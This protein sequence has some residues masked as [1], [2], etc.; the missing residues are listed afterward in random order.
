MGTSSSG[1]PTPMK[2]GGLAK[3]R[4]VMF[5]CLILAWIAAAVYFLMGA[6]IVTVPA[7]SSTDAPPG[8]VYIAA[9]CYLVGGL[10]ILAR[11]RWLWLVGLIMNTLVI[12]FFIMMYINKPAVMFSI[13]GMA[14][15]IPQL[16]IEIGL[17]YLIANYKYINL[18]KSI[19][20]K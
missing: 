4:V 18:S 19:N 11:R 1:E 2:T 12:V 15:K 13:A 20:Y 7:L 17:V 9:G 6:G 10:L 8:I 5:A 16:L 3:V 14:T